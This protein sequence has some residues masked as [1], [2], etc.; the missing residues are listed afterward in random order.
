MTN[1]PFGLFIRQRR[2]QLGLTLTAFARL[3]GVRIQQLDKI[4]L[5]AVEVPSRE[6]IQDMATILDLD[7][8]ECYFAAGIVPGDIMEALPRHPETWAEIR[9]LI[10]LTHEDG[11]V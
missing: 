7:L 4:E 11:G 8:D 6:A 3:L 2:L 9:K 1:L 10:G 5:A